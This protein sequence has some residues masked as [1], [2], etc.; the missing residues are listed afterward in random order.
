MTLSQ[1]G[2]VQAFLA[3]HLPTN[4][5]LLC[6]KYTA[7]ASINFELNLGQCTSC[8]FNYA[9]LCFMD[10]VKEIKHYNKKYISAM[11]AEMVKV[12]N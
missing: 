12:P 8:Y 2:R 1:E 7:E 11:L 9:C 6:Y 4:F 3:P 5:L 10:L